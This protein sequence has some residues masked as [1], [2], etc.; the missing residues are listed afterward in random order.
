MRLYLSGDY[1]KMF[2]FKSTKGDFSFI[3]YLA[4]MGI[5]V[6]REENNNETDIH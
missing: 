2:P 3:D 1:Y 5:E 6:I 4:S